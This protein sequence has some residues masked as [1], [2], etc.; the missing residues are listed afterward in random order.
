MNVPLNPV[1]GQAQ[2]DKYVFS[3]EMWCQCMYIG[4]VCTSLCSLILQL[5]SCH[6]CC[7]EACKGIAG[8]CA[9][10]KVSL[11]TALFCSLVPEGSFPWG[12]IAWLL[13]QLEL[14]FPKFQGHD[15]TLHLT[16]IPFPQDWEFHQGM[17]AAAQ[18]AFSGLEWCLLSAG[19]TAGL[20]DPLRVFSNLNKFY[21]YMKLLPEVV[22]HQSYQSSCNPQPV[23]S[24][25][26]DVFVEEVLQPSTDLMSLYLSWAAEK[27][28]GQSFKAILW[29]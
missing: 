7:R 1:L 26:A 2:G 23:P 4:Y 22:R 8:S 6:A 28:A 24:V 16:H 20:S 5:Q 14:C 13:E 27:N 10:W 29:N 19:L 17:I 15:F 21:D 18:A 9:L 11:N 12:P 3:R 25:A